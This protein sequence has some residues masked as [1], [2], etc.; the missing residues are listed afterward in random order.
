MLPPWYI[1]GF[2]D[3]EAAFTYSKTGSRG[4]LNLYFSIKVNSDD[5][6][7]IEEIQNF[8]GVG[9][10]YSVKARPPGPY[11]G[12]TRAAA[13]YRVQRI[14]ELD[15]IVQ[16]FDK[17]PL[18]SKKAKA[19]Q[20]WKKIFA[21]KKNFRKPDFAKLE[22]LI[23]ELSGLNSKNSALLKKKKGALIGQNNICL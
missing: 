14:G 11:S 20:A 15:R 18:S 8:F 9:R 19:Y 5:R 16:H 12:P 17:Y 21:L 1:T 2:C 3:G 23:L 4:N 7:L 6:L 13:Y 22:E 10:I